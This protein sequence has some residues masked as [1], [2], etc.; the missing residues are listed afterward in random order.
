MKK[1]LFLTLLTT[2]SMNYTHQSVKNKKSHTAQYKVLK[3][4]TKSPKNPSHYQI[5]DILNFLKLPK[6]ATWK[7]IDT[8]LAAAE[9]WIMTD[10]PDPDEIEIIKH[11][12]YAI[13][14]ISAAFHHLKH[15]V[16]PFLKEL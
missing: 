13:D 7:E 11:V 15:K 2:V 4:F 9:N 14:T 12:D 10:F 3:H 6:N 5:L 16:G 8:T 1:L